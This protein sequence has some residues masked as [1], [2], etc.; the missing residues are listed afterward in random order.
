MPL[1][2]S[3]VLG[4][5]LYRRAPLLCDKVPENERPSALDTTIPEIQNTTQPGPPPT[6]STEM[7]MNTTTTAGSAGHT[8]PSA[9][10][11]RYVT[12]RSVIVTASGL[13]KNDLESGNWFA[14]QPLGGG[15]EYAGLEVYSE[16]HTSNI[17]QDDVLDL[18]G[19]VRDLGEEQLPHVLALM[20]EGQDW[21]EATST[22]ELVR[23]PANY[24]VSYTHLELCATKYEWRGTQTVPPPVVVPAETFGYGCTAE[25]RKYEGMLVRIEGA[26][27]QPCDNSLTLD[28]TSPLVHATIRNE[29]QHCQANTL[30]ADVEVRDKFGQIWIKNEASG[31]ASA[32]PLEA[33]RLS[34]QSSRCGSP[35]RG[36]PTSTRRPAPPNRSRWR[37]I[38][39]R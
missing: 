4:Q 5:D 33:R 22:P 12:L 17:K 16:L 15:D 29:A 30:P 37:T 1:L 27:V 18:T 28:L 7:C 38:F 6:Q 10:A 34:P 20:P 25:A 3:A 26:S 21:Y 9:Y 32:Y 8:F 24:I 13:K 39:C 14:V 35:A 11:G 19:Y 2:A 23:T 31:P 36:P